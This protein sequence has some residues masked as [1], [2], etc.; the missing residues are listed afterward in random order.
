MVEIITKDG[1]SLDLDPSA[2]FEIEMENP[3]LSDS[4]IPVAFSTSIL[5]LPTL[6]NKKVF[7]YISAMLQD[8]TIKKIEASIHA[9]GIP[10]FY[11]I[12]EYDSIG[13]GNLNYTFTGRDL[14]EEWG[15]YIHELKTMT[16][17]K[18]ENANYH[19]II[20]NTPL[21]AILGIHRGQ[22]NSRHFDFPMLVNQD[23][24]TEIEHKNNLGKS[25]IEPGVKYNNYWWGVFSAPITPAV[26]VSYILSQIFNNVS[27]DKEIENRINNLAILALHRSRPLCNYGLQ[28]DEN[29]YLVLP[30]A[31][32]LPECSVCDLV[33]NILKMFCSSFFRDG[34]KFAI[35][36]NKEIITK[37]ADRIWDDKLSTVISLTKEPSY[38][39]EFAYSNDDENSY[40]AETEGDGSEGSILEAV[41]MANVVDLA[42]KSKDDYVAIRENRT[43]DMFSGRAVEI[44]LDSGKKTLS[45]I[46]MIYHN[47]GEEP[48]MS[49]EGDT[50]DNTVDF[51]CVK[52]IPIHHTSNEGETAYHQCPIIKLSAAGDNRPTDVMIGCLLNGQL[53]DKGVAFVRQGHYNGGWVAEESNEETIDELC[54][55][56]P[57]LLYRK[58]HSDFA[59]WISKERRVV[60]ADVAL[61]LPEI[62]SLRMYDKISVFNQL[63]LIKKISYG[64]SVQSDFVSSKVDL[65]EC[66]TTPVNAVNGIWMNKRFSIDDGATFYIQ[67]EHPVE[68]DVIIA[69]QYTSGGEEKSSILRI[70]KGGTKSNVIYGVPNTESLTIEQ[71]IGADRVFSYVWKGFVNQ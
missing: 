66:N 17:W 26:R 30:I 32:M 56:S 46:D 45:S 58:Y 67:S 28:Q 39:Y 61:S 27:I 64:F 4:H 53:V 36:C 29:R 19:H 22:I 37:K 18:G 40:T 12:L 55:I 34:Q 15:E 13:D 7:G 20:S 59:E 47:L 49:A 24:M 62:A 54:S 60:S 43:G 1:I 3:M 10:L 5:F 68:T 51:K 23:A 44:T 41:G 21:G 38:S 16:V 71:K 52:C 65:I 11:G 33:A 35:K 70:L 31:D 9:G 69:C 48:S 42:E 2:E 14:E 6:K 63:F 57:D 8:P 25:P 50:F